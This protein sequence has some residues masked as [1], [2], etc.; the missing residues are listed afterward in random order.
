MLNFSNVLTPSPTLGGQY[1]YIPQVDFEIEYKTTRGNIAEAQ[2]S[3][4][5]LNNV[6]LSSTFDDGTYVDVLEEDVIIQIQE[7]N[8]EYLSENFRL[9]VFIEETQESPVPG[10][11]QTKYYRPLVFGN[12][13]NKIVNGM[14]VSDSELAEQ[15]EDIAA[16]AI[17]SGFVEYY[18]TVN[19]DKEIASE[20]I[21]ALTNQI[22]ERNFHISDDFRCEDLESGAG[23]DIY[24]SNID[25]NDLED[26]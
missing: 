18:F 12:Q 8:S 2:S 25:P 7:L 19:V 5:G 4:D 21:C 3:S 22:R 10:V 9:E 14:V 17:D 20:E 23:L 6:N 15:E 11:A 13:V 24:S 16:Q 1:S 26:C